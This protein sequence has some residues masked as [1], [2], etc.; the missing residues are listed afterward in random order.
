[1]IVGQ[2][3]I[4]KIEIVNDIK[5]NSYIIIYIKVRMFANQRMP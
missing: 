5:I 3:R 1:M 2:L 4:F